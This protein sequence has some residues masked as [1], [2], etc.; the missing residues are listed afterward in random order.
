MSFKPNS[1]F[2]KKSNTNMVL[3]G[4][5][6]PSRV[7]NARENARRSSLIGKK[8][9]RFTWVVICFVLALVGY[10]IGALTGGLISLA[11]E[12]GFFQGA[13][14]GGISGAVF[15]IEAAESALTIWRS[16][17]SVIWSILYMMDIVCSLLSGRL[18]REKVG[19][20]FRSAVQSQISAAFSPLTV[21]FDIFETSSSHGMSRDSVQKLP[22]TII[23]KLNKSD[24]SGICC[25]VCLQDFKIGDLA[26]I[27]VCCQHRFHLSCIDNWLMRQ[28]SCPLCRQDF[29]NCS[30]VVVVVGY[31]G[32]VWDGFLTAS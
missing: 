30:L 24:F 9:G 28:S 21:D 17:D 12:S 7:P 15:T 29:L 20:A 32:F 4:S 1:S 14:I 27:L 5:S 3:V 26:R 13:G 25:V 19:P 6:S 8:I 10:F 23:T 31:F 18:V 11:T 16:N 22:K 2:P